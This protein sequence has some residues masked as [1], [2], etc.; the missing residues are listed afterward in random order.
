MGEDT[1]DKAQPFKA[2]A[3]AVTLIS[4]L[5]FIAGFAFRWSY[6]YNFGVQH[7]VYNLNVHAILFSSMEMIKQPW[8][9][10]A[11]VLCVGGTLI[12]ID[13]LITGARHIAGWRDGGKVRTLLASVARQLGAENPLLTDCVRAAV[14]IYVVYM[15]SSQMGYNQFKKHIVNSENPLPRVTV[16]L[17]GEADAALACGK[18]SK[19]MSF[20]GNG[21][22]IH[23]LEEYHRTCT[24][25]D[26]VWRL[27]YRDEKSIYLF[28]SEKEPGGRPLTIVMPNTDK[29]ILVTE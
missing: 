22:R 14:L 24:S 27:L 18:E 4:A 13:L 11:T 7:L 21:H 19:D 9:L 28:A 8:N 10:L 6:Y 25:E 3:A 26:S 29:V 5:L 16:I 20:I 1:P 12:I 15:L 17:R 23:E 2:L